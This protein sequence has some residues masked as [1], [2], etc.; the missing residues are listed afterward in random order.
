MILKESISGVTPKE[1]RGQLEKLPFVYD[2]AQVLLLLLVMV[3]LLLLLLP[4]TPSLPFV[5][6]TAQ[7]FVTS[8][9]SALTSFG[10]SLFLVHKYP[11]VC[12]GFCSNLCCSSLK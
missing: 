1:L 9:G 10:S 3:V 2:T 11:S 6:E 5:Y 12:M 4:L 8:F 7:V